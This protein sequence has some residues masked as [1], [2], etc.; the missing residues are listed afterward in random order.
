M[1]RSKR[2]GERSMDEVHE[3]SR[4]DRMARDIADILDR[5]GS[6]ERKIDAISNALVSGSARGKAETRQGGRTRNTGGRKQK[7]KTQR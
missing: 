5:L 2:A 6:L 4:A 1:I 3:L 7:K